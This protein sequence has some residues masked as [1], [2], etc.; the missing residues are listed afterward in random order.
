[1]RSTIAGRLLRVPRASVPACTLSPGPLFS[2][3]IIVHFGAGAAEASII[4]PVR[5]LARITHARFAGMR[6]KLR[7]P[8]VGFWQITPA[9]RP[10][11]RGRLPLGRVVPISRKCPQ[12]DSYLQVSPG[13]P[14]CA[15]AESRKTAG[16]D[17][18]E[19]AITAIRP[20][21][22]PVFS[23]TCRPH[24]Q[25]PPSPPATLNSKRLGLAR[26]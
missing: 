1:M 2:I 5:K 15:S 25:N 22:H 13:P 21:S 24:A 19:F 16:S 26:Q 6:A 11:D 8:E 18:P 20:E 4:R 3:S 14:I 7:H 9:E 12:P 23:S 10:S 17:C